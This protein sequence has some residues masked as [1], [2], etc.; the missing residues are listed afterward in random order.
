MTEEVKH[1]LFSSVTPPS[2]WNAA[3]PVP[4]E[5]HNLLQMGVCFSRMQSICHHFFLNGIPGLPST[6]NAG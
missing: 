2:R 5:Q 3:A 1:V 4:V 6:V